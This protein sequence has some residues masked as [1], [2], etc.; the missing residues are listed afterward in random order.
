MLLFFVPGNSDYKTKNI[1]EKKT[2]K[3]GFFYLKANKKNILRLYPKQER[4]VT[5]YLK[6]NNVDF[7]SWEDLEKLFQY[8][9]NL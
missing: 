3:W 6:V 1:F 2:L 8:L 5:A 4:A 9:T 7:N